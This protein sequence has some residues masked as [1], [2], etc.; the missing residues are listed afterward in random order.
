MHDLVLFGYVGGRP[1]RR[2][3]S[4]DSRAPLAE[5]CLNFGDGW[6][7][8]PENDA[9]DR[10]QQVEEWTSRLGSYHAPA[11]GFHFQCRQLSEFG[12]FHRFGSVA[13]NN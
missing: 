5:R 4:R 7:S 6:A 11:K 2:F 10:E 9:E 13:G 12:G 8:A 3:F 1:S